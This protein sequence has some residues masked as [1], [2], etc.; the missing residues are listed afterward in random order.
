MKEVGE[1]V[2]EEAMRKVQGPAARSR[3]VFE[4]P[5][6]ANRW[7]PGCESSLGEGEETW[8]WGPWG[9]RLVLQSEHE[10]QWTVEFHH[11]LRD[12]EAES[13]GSEDTAGLQH[14]ESSL[15]AGRPQVRRMSGEG[16]CK[17]STQHVQR[18]RG[19]KPCGMAREL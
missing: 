5:S 15:E 9:Q 14:Q 11:G 19:V 1:I 3:P 17:L 4:D 13:D 6:S 16:H 18:P 7:R 10:M 2:D 8:R 12:E